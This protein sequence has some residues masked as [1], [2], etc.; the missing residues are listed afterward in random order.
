MV[1][2]W[3]K[4][5]S[6][7]SGDVT[8]LVRMV[9]R[10]S[11]RGRAGRNERNHVRSSNTPAPRLLTAAWVLPLCVGLLITPNAS[12]CSIPVFRYAL[13]RWR[14]DPY[15][16]L[17][18]HRGE[19]TH[20]QR[21]LLE[22]LNPEY[23]PGEPFPN[24]AVSIVDLDGEVRPEFEAIWEN[25]Q[26]D[27]LPWIVLRTPWRGENQT[28]WAGALTD[29]SIE[30][31]LQSPLR[32]EIV[33]RLAGGESIV[34]VLIDGADASN[35]ERLASECNEHLKSLQQSIELPAIRP[36]DL[37][38]LSVEPDSLDLRFSLLRLDREEPDER[39]LIESMLSVQ[40]DLNG[41]DHA[42][43]PLLFPVFGRGRAFFPLVGD[44]IKPQSLEDL[45]RFLS[46]AC[47]CTIKR[48]NP[49]VD[50]LTSIDWDA[51]V[52]GIETERPLPPLTGLAGF[53]DA[54]TTNSSE[55]TIERDAGPIAKTNSVDSP[56]DHAHTPESLRATSHASNERSLGSLVFWIGGL[57]TGVAVIVSLWVVSRPS[58]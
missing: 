13:E 35:N 24:T 15:E 9:G 56:P 37:A 4:F 51:Y 29:A 22:R 52:L 3:N 14:P 33:R 32:S 40:P 41:P 54:P 6:L 27:S 10:D 19:L 47:Q 17:V 45:A 43:K 42:G 58:P 50:L 48:Q 20:K 34:W 2:R 55:A 30:T 31:I 57:L 44:D 25:E 49:G 28:V 39:I 26:S 16:V 12:A 36:E 53:G 18:Y 7:C 5:E 8:L 21:E 23:V 46:G 38:D 11:G 1:N